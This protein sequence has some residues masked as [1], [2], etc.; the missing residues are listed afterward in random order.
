MRSGR[1]HLSDVSPAPASEV[2]RLLRAFGLRAGVLAVLA[3][4]IGQTSLAIVLALV[5]SWI[6][7]PPVDWSRHGWRDA[8]R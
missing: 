3:V 2:T 8:S 4:L 1:E 6:F 5:G 7:F